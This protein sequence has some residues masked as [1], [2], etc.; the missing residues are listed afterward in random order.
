MK[1]LAL[2]AA[3]GGLA[4]Y[5]YDPDLGRTRRGHLSSLLQEN[6]DNALQAGYAAS[7]TIESARPLARRMSKAIA[8]GDW[9]EAIGRRRSAA[10][11]PRLIGA[12][13]IG[14]VVVYFMDPVRGSMRRT[15]AMAA[16][17]RAAN[18]VADTV[19]PLAGRVGDHVATAFDG[20][21]SKAS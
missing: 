2:G 17:R 16:G 20:V 14:G 10:T 21:K 7:E 9:A 18:R 11:L 12:A 5:F 8:R 15:S 4:V 1:R 3:L 19:K 6:R 13:V